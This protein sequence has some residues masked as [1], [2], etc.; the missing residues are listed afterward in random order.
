M[1]YLDSEEKDLEDALQTAVVQNF[2]KPSTLEQ[3]Q[4]KDAAESFVKK[5]EQLNLSM[6]I[7]FSP[8]NY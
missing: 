7:S 1:H 4:F 6:E 2:P 5:E 3:K 8:I